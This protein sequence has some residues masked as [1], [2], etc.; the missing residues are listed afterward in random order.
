M[1]FFIYLGKKSVMI[2]SKDSVTSLVSDP[3]TFKFL[4]FL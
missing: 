3:E 1:L 2:F 4:T